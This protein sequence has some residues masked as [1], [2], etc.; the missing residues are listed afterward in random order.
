MG[1]WFIPVY[2][3]SHETR[4]RGARLANEGGMFCGNRGL[5]VGGGNERKEPVGDFRDRSEPSGTLGGAAMY[6]W[7][8]S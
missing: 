2:E 5:A 4:R 7:Q 3:F 6:L 8:S 1:I